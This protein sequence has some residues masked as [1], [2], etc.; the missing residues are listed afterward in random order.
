MNMAYYDILRYIIHY[1]C[2]FCGFIA[3]KCIVF[4]VC[5]DGCKAEATPLGS[6]IWLK[7]NWCQL[8]QP[9]ATGLLPFFLRLT[10]VQESHRG[11]LVVYGLGALGIW[12][13]KQRNQ[14]HWYQQHWNQQ[15]LD[16]LLCQNIRHFVDIIMCFQYKWQQSHL[17]DCLCIYSS[18]SLYVYIYILLYTHAD[19]ANN[20]RVILLTTTFD[21]AR[22]IVQCNDSMTH[23]FKCKQ[24]MS[25]MTDSKWLNSDRTEL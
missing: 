21:W 12:P 11:S 15:L 8:F 7:L 6:S 13:F 5:V 25:S 18:Y 3:P 22:G 24:L 10:L 9:H 17:F 19:N 4:I 2:C 16:M 20:Y 23:L 14:K 1:A